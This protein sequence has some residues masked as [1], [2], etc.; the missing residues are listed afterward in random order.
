MRLRFIEYKNG[1][2]ASRYDKYTSVLYASGQDVALEGL[3]TGHLYITNAYRTNQM[4]RDAA[5]RAES[6]NIGIH[7]FKE[8][9]PEI[10][11]GKARVNRNATDKKLSNNSDDVTVAW[12]SEVETH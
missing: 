11:R 4:Y 10:I 8:V 2:P 6:Q 1:V 7:K 5:N 3:R 12:M 9:H